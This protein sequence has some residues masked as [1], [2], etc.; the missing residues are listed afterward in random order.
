MNKFVISLF[1]F[2]VVVRAS[3]GDSFD[4]DFDNIDIDEILENKRLVDNYIHCFK[5][6]QKCTPEGQKFRD[7]LPKALKSKCNDCTEEQKEKVYKSLEWAIQNRPDDFLEI[8]AIHD[9]DHH[10]RADFAS[11]LADRHIVLPPPK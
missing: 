1:V 6:G 4:D 5:T 10:F 2:V 8:E 11:E 7:L 3:R 9:P